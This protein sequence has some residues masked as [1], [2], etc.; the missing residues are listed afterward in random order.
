MP[1][2]PLSP[3]EH[4]A[5][6][7]ARTLTGRMAITGALAMLAAALGQEIKDLMTFG[8]MATPSFLGS[9]LMHIGA[10]GA[11]YLAGQAFPTQE[12][13]LPPSARK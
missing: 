1:D 9:T 2:E 11:A 12:R 3:A 6:T 7:R 10:V 13:L 8:Q 5:V 4:D